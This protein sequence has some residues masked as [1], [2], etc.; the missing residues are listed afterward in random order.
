MDNTEQTFTVYRI[1]FIACAVLIVIAIAL[2]LLLFFV[3]DIR[4]MFMQIRT[5]NPKPKVQDGS[6]SVS[7]TELSEPSFETAILQSTSETPNKSVS[8]AI[9]KD[10]LA[11]TVT[12]ALPD[13]DTAPVA[14]RP[15]FRFILTERTIIIHTAENI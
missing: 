5:T 1:G 13:R 14:V 2:V 6:S 4:H 8:K 9:K 10:D 12:L 15:E 11:E 3:F 7:E